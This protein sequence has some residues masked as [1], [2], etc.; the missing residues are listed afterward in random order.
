MNDFLDRVPQAPE[1]KDD[2]AAEKHHQ[3]PSLI[4]QLMMGADA[5]MQL[6]N[7]NLPGLTPEQGRWLYEERAQRATEYRERAERIRYW[8]ARAE[9]FRDNPNVP[10]DDMS[11]PIVCS[12]LEIICGPVPRELYR[13]AEWLIVAAHLSTQG[14]TYFWAP[15]FSG[16]TSNLAKAGRYTEEEA[17]RREI[18]SERME[19]AVLLTEAEA[20]SFRAVSDVNAHRWFHDRFPG[21][22]ADHDLNFVPGET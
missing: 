17:K 18:W 21:N 14:V 3:M 9:A 15:K 10:L 19:V 8:I 2:L 12:M 5:W 1:P 7:Q 6:A 13:D 11:G 20:M 4:N 16:Y 22:R